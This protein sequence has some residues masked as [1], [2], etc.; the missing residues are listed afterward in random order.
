MFQKHTMIIL[1][2]LEM[3]K[4]EFDEKFIF[5]FGTL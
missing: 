1:E 3:K 5:G 4:T 2:N